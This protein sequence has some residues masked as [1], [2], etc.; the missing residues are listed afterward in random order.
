MEWNVLLED[1][2]FLIATD[3][4]LQDDLAHVCEILDDASSGPD[5]PSEEPPRKPKRVRVNRQKA[6]IRELQK[7]VTSLQAKLAHDKTKQLVGAPL[8]NSAWA[9]AARLEH[10]ERKRAVRENEHLRAAVDEQSVFIQHVQASLA[11]KPRCGS[12]GHD[13]DWQ[14]YKLAAH[15]S[16]RAAAIHAIADRQYRRLTNVFIRAGVV[17]PVEPL[18]RAAPIVLPTGQRV[19]EIVNVARLPLCFP[20][21]MDACWHTFNGDTG[22]MLLDDGSD[23][24]VERIDD[25]TNYER[26]RQRRPDESVAYTNTVRKLY[27]EDDRSVVVFRS[28]LEDAVVPHMSRGSVDNMSGWVVAS[29]HPTDAASC[30]LTSVVYMPLEDLVQ[31]GDNS[32]LLAED[33][34]VSLMAAFSFSASTR[35]A[36]SAVANAPHHMQSFFARAKMFDT[37]MKAALQD[38]IAKA[39]ST[40]AAHEGTT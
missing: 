16:L 18:H 6:E 14:S 30:W 24:T 7:Q 35:D 11:K 36:S 17:D 15:A 40:G 1:L 29:Q 28:V 12:S 22:P 2:E 27:E 5:V 31:A 37:A 34:L 20:A 33:Q 32:S 4:D 38:A 8:M 3:E 13:D 10:A 25:R 21:A 26:F 19:L 9:R 39:Q 23:E